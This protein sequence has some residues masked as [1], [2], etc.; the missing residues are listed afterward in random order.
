MVAFAFAQLSA[1]D[2]VHKD[3]VAEDNRQ[4]HQC[5]HQHEDVGRGRRRRLPDGQR[6]RHEVGEI[7]DQ[8]SEIAEQEQRDGGEKGKD[9]MAKDDAASS[10]PLPRSRAWVVAMYITS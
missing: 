10:N 1:E 3:H 8:K 9:F 7:R 4:H 2:P 5:A 6:R